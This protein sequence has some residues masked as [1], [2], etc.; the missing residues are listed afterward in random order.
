MMDRIVHQGLD[1][2]DTL[3]LKLY[4]DMCTSSKPLGQII[5]H[6]SRLSTCRAWPPYGTH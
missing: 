2:I 3:L 6:G 4:I 5:P 1:G